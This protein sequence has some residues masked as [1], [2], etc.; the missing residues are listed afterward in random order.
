LAREIRFFEP[1]WADRDSKK[2][3]RKCT[4]EQQEA[5]LEEIAALIRALSSCRHPATDPQL[6]PWK[7]TA[8]RVPGLKGVEL[9]EYRCRYPLRIIARWVHPQGP[10]AEVVLLVA[11]T[12]SHDHERLRDALERHRSAIRSWDPDEVTP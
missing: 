9:M 8:Y 7:P 1:T 5:W 3:L 11:A 12:L 10:S 2:A 4:S 6:A